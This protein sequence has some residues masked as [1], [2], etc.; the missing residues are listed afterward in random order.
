MLSTQPNGGPA[1]TK[2]HGEWVRIYPRAAHRG[3]GP[4][5]RELGS[6]EVGDTRALRVAYLVNQYPKVS[7]SFIRRE[8]AALEEHGVLVDRFSVRRCGDGAVDPADREELEKTRVILDGGAL[9][10]L[11]AALTE[12]MRRPLRWLGA[13]ALA[14]RVGGR[15]PR[16][17]LRHLVYLLEACV[18]RSWLRRLGVRHLHAH[19]GTNAT[20]V[21][22]LCRQ[23]GGPPFS[24]TVHGPEDFEQTPDLIEKVKRAAFTVAVCDYSRSEVVSRTRR[25]CDPRVHVVH[26]GVD[27]LFLHAEP[28]P[29][30]VEPRLVCVGRLSEEKGQSVLIEAAARLVA[31]GTELD[32]VLVGDGP[33]RASL[34]ELIERYGLQDS[35]RIV[36][37]RSGPDVR[38]EL[39]AAR[40]LVLPS[41][42]EGLPVV[43]M[44]SLALGRP[45]VCSSVG[46]V[47]ELVRGRETGWL[48]AS[49]DVDELT[50]ALRNVLRA[51]AELL[52][53]YGAAGR[54]LVLD[55]HDSS[56]EAGRL[57]DLIAASFHSDTT[58][59]ANKDLCR[60]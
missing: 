21:A 25:T 12:G 7:H 37:W 39:C 16:G 52:E 58:V 15:S 50:A 30:P 46:G 14:W 22:M 48:V 40:A 35:V 32:L 45:V 47:S 44:E 26:C 23:L 9:G 3:L 1:P 34:E 43:V 57:A 53:R 60:S 6:V 24:F 5:G 55:H 17:R 42:F 51:P 11:S 18:C 29:C 4:V 20:T 49:G 2:H 13:L 33:T 10:L 54:R 31:E 19:F 28:E 8:I 38:A 56:T 59:S 27:D 41:F 36:G